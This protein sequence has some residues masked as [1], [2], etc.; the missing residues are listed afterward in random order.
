MATGRIPRWLDATP[1][2]AS[3]PRRRVVRQV[4][5]AYI[6]VGVFS[7][8]ASLA[9]GRDPLTCHGW[10]GAGGTASVLLSLGLGLCLGT[11]TIAATRAIVG[12]SGWGRALHAAL[13][14]AVRRATDGELLALGIA[15][16]TGEE[17]LF[18]GLLVPTAGVVLSSL[19]FGGLHQVRG[20]GR[21][22]W[23][24]WATIMGVLFG[25][26]FVATGSLVGPLVAHVVIN[27]INLRFVRDNDPEPPRP[28]ALGGL[29]RR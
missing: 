7:A 1:A 26:M 16:A 19:I 9:L 4:L 15:S 5:A 28:R 22:G 24:A 13:R 21:L 14:P 23:M 17:L 18:R 11:L 6:A 3:D 25:V 27:Q 12:R 29:L 20:P 2:P 10:L 8:L